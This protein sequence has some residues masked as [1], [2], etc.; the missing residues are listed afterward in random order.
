LE[1]SDERQAKIFREDA[2]NKFG[3][4]CLSGCIGIL[5][6]VRAHVAGGSICDGLELVREK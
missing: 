1:R 2:K 3:G 6:R 5:E 4:S